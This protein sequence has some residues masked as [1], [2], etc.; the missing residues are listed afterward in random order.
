MNILQVKALDAAT[1]ADTLHSF[2]E[3]NQIDFQKMI[4][5]GYDGAATFSRCILEF[6]REC[7]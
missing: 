3:C 2:M 4:G 6:R 5:Q 1:I 7:V